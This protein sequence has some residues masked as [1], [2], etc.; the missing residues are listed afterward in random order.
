MNFYKFKTDFENL[1]I[2][3]TDPE[4][5]E[6]NSAIFDQERES[7]II[8][9]LLQVKNYSHNISI[10]DEQINHLKQLKEEEKDK[11]DKLKSVLQNEITQKEKFK[12]PLVSQHWRKNQ[13]E[14][15]FNQE[16]DIDFDLPEDLVKIKKAV[17]KTE[18]RKLIN[19][20]NSYNNVGFVPKPD[21]LII[22]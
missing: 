14:M 10:I 22:K 5:G 9:A 1:L 16:F 4:T 18:L 7:I 2:N 11:R 6:I 19:E 13:D 8:D 3:N 12:T 20:G 21:S 17:N 15:I